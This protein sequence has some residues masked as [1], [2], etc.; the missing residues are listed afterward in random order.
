MKK[1]LVFIGAGNVATHLAKALYKNGFSILQVFSRTELSAKTLADEVSA[2]YT[3]DYNT[4][5]ENADIYFYCLTD[6]VLPELITQKA[7][8]NGIHIHTA[9]SVKMDVFEMNRTNYGVL[10]PLQTFSKNKEIDFSKVPLFI[11]A[12]NEFSE[13][14]IK[15][16]AMSLS[17]KVYTVSSDNRQK[18][19]LSAVFACNFTNHLFSIAQE[20]LGEV[21]FDVLLPLIEETVE[22]VKT[23]SPRK[24]QTGPAIRKDNAV[25]N[26]HLESLSFNSD[27]QDI[28]KKLTRDIQKES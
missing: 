23:I 4:I 14:V 27:W 5:I 24:A 8:P 22:K 19:H 21:P 6:D 28:Y 17:Q 1:N 25:I 26:K 3:T 10:Y 12:N 16:L 11:E 15:D 2:N 13:Q 20:L 18:I 9:G 7:L